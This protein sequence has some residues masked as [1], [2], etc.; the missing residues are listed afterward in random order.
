[1]WAF[2]PDQ[3]KADKAKKDEFKNKLSIIDQHLAG[4]QFL[5]GKSLTVAD[6]LAVAYICQPLG[7]CFHEKERAQLKNLMSWV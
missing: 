2:A 1:M 6:I 3:A 5:V 4:R 7:F